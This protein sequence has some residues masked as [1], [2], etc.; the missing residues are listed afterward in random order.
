VSLGQ[1]EGPSYGVAFELAYRRCGPSHP[2]PACRDEERS[3]HLA[4]ICG[5]RS[6]TGERVVY[7]PHP[8]NGYTAHGWPR[9]AFNLMQ[10]DPR[11][12]TCACCHA[13]V[14]NGHLL[15]NACIHKTATRRKS[16]E[17]I[18]RAYRK[19]MGGIAKP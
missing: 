10:W 7:P 1:Q 12:L 3:L 9:W 8:C 5:I 17:C 11:T 13:P 19:A 14:G 2:D 6:A 18:A 4:R 16:V 15:C